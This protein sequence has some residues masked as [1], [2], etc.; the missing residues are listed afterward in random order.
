MLELLH[1]YATNIYFIGVVGPMPRP[2]RNPY[3]LQQE[4]EVWKQSGDSKFPSFSS[5]RICDN[6]VSRR[7]FRYLAQN[8]AD[9]NSKD[10]YNRTPL[11][12]SAFRVSKF[13][14]NCF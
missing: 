7:H 1:F 13:N 10:V 6:S 9:V 4:K 2:E 12:M 11:Y 14:R 5:I 8:G 3:L